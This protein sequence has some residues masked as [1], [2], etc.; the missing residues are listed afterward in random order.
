M[1]TWF[2]KKRK[3]CLQCICLK[4]LIEKMSDVGVMGMEV[5]EVG[6]VVAGV[7]VIKFELPLI[8]GR[9]SVERRPRTY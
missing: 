9:D 7:G 1:C 8:G 4:F 5:S 3:P 6:V 2:H